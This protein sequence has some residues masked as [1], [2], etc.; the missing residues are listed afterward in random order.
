VHSSHGLQGKEGVPAVLKQMR[1]YALSRED[2]DFIT[3]ELHHV[4]AQPLA[5]CVF[6]PSCCS[7]PACAHKVLTKLHLPRLTCCP[8]VTKFK[9]KGNWGEDPMKAV[10]TQVGAMQCC[11]CCACWACWACSPCDVLHLLGALYTLCWRTLH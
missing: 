9:T 5:A 11:A 7:F 10:E 4:F 2:I 6:V 1:D 8:D 3:G